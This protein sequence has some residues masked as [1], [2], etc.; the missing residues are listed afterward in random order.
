MAVFWAGVT[1]ESLGCV[2][3]CGLVVDGDSQGQE[4]L[5]F[6][7]NASGAGVLSLVETESAASRFCLLAL[8]LGVIIKSARDSE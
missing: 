2:F 5:C 1:I 3:A 8:L 7:S 4:G 6:V